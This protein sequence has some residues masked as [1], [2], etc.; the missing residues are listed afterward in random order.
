MASVLL[1]TGCA[2]NDEP[3]P[4]VPASVI[5]TVP[6]DLCDRI[7]YTIANPAF[8]EAMPIP[9][10]DLDRGPDFR[11]AQGF[12]GGDGYAGGFVTARVQTFGSRDEARTG[13]ERSAPASTAQPFEGGS[14][15]VADAVR[16]QNV[17]EEDTKVEVLDANVIVEVRLTAP[18]PVSDEQAPQLPPASVKI[19]IQ[20]LELIRSS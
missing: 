12:F 3:A 13:F 18:N 8:R 16:Y 1:L 6:T 5:H 19:A 20:T 15:I 11:C 7:D 2:S 14:D 9:P 4:A 17:S 10:K